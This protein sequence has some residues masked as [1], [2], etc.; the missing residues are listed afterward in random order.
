M[1]IARFTLAVLLCGF[2]FAFLG[3]GKPKSAQE[4]HDQGMSCLMAGGAGPAEAVEYFSKAIE[5]DP[6]FVKSYNCRGVAYV[7]L[8]QYDKAKADFEKALELD[9][10]YDLARD[11]L[12]NLEAGNYDQASAVEF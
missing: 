11:N 7:M 6:H 8:E 1:R 5:Q 4:Y 12:R 3:C 10:N 2:L 9:P